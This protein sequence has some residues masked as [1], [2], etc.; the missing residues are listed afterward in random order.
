M[1]SLSF[2]D[3]WIVDQV[4]ELLW[5]NRLMF[6]GKKEEA[7]IKYYRFRNELQPYKIIVS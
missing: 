5:V 1:T 2:L 6:Q 3:Y 7:N 4:I